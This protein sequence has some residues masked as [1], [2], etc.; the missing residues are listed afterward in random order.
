MYEA[1]C[2]SLTDLKPWMSWAHDNYQR[3]ETL[4]WITV[5]QARWTDG[6]YYGFSISDAKRNIFL[7]SCSLSQLHPIYHFCNLGYWIRSTQRGHGFAGRAARLAARFAF[8]RVGLIRAEV[9]IAVGNDASVKVAEKM[10]AHYEGIL[11]NRMVIRDFI[12]DAHMYSLLPSDFGL[13]PRL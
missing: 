1:V 9:V 7:G 6:A 4:D 12:C 10:R 3:Q 2:E 5:A 13:V 8:E 11:R